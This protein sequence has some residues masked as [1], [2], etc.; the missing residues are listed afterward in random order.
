MPVTRTAEWTCSICGAVE[1]TTGELPPGWVTYEMCGRNEH[2]VV[3]NALE[4]CGSCARRLCE[5][6]SKDGGG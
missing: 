1:V 2:A 3:P 6:K 4:V 5:M